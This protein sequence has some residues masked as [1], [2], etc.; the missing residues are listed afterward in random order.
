MTTNDTKSMFRCP[1]CRAFTRESKP[2]SCQLCGYTGDFIQPGHEHLYSC[3]G[4]HT[5][6][7]EMR[8][9]GGGCA[10]RK[11]AKTHGLR[12]VVQA[13]YVRSQKAVAIHEASHAVVGAAL[14]WPVS[15]MKLLD[16]NEPKHNCPGEWAG[17]TRVGKKDQDRVELDVL[18][19]SQLEARASICYAG[20]IGAEMYLGREIEIEEGGA[21]PDWKT[22]RGVV[23]YHKAKT[24]PVVKECVSA[25]FA[26]MF[27]PPEKVETVEKLLQAQE[28]RLLGETKALLVKHWTTV[29]KLAARICEAKDTH[30]TLDEPELDRL[31]AEVRSWRRPSAW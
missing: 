20:K 2:R 3:A 24:D 8:Y 18:T 10:C 11:L 19:D 23:A 30:W 21:G 27:L 29:E 9:G 25:P 28:N 17:V 13:E 6:G 16:G 22:A 15:E 14:G 26:S 7:D 12:V 5:N 4:W 1:G 31:L